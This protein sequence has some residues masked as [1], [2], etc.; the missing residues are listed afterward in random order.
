MIRVA[1]F[2]TSFFISPSCAAIAGTAPSPAQ[3][4]VTADPDPLHPGTGLVLPANLIDL[5]VSGELLYGLDETGALSVIDSAGPPAPALPARAAARGPETLR[6][7]GD[8][9]AM[10]ATAPLLK[11]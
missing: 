9:L 11:S 7:S 1:L 10:A 4:C 5:V 8:S 6:V 3:D 2:P